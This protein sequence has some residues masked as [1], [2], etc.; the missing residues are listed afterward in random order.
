[1]SNLEFSDGNYYCRAWVESYV[2]SNIIILILAVAISLIN[3]IVKEILRSK[4]VMC[5]ALYRVDQI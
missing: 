2:S 4:L 1:M 3:V 5:N